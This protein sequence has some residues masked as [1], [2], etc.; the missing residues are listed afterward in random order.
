MFAF[1][2]TFAKNVV[3]YES[4]KCTNCL[5]L[6]ADLVERIKREAKRQKKSVNTFAIEVSGRENQL[7]MAKKT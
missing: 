6:S 4:G 2:Y 1:C 3:H 7:G 5:P